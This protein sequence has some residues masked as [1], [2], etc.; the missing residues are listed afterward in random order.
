MRRRG[1]P[2]APPPGSRIRPGSNR[3]GPASRET[4]SRDQT[5]RSPRPSAAQWRARARDRHVEALAGAVPDEPRVSSLCPSSRPGRS[6]TSADRHRHQ[7]VLSPQHRVD[8]PSLQVRS[9]GSDR[10]RAPDPAGVGPEPTGRDGLGA[11]CRSTSPVIVEVSPGGSGPSASRR[12]RQ[13]LR[14]RDTGVRCR[15]AVLGELK[16][17]GERGA[18]SVRG[19]TS[20][21]PAVV[22][23]ATRTV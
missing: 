22:S 8:R 19:A 7:L 5:G 10:P 3:G 18:E 12:T 4:R 1:G 16:S 6:R 2:A 21:V 20:G 15:R 11:R 9:A 17:P 13:V 14:S 23:S